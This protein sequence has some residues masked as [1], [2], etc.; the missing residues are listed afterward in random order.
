M[1]KTIVVQDKFRTNEL[2]VQP[3]G[4]TVTVSHS[5]GSHRVYK[6]IKNPRAYTNSIVKD[7]TIISVQVDGQAYWAR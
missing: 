5:D 7:E 2:S 6:N 3:G 1:S 4:S